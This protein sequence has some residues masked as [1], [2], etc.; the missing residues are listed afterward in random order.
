MKKILVVPDAHARPDQNN[1]RFTALGQ[2]ICDK[3]PDIVVSIGDWADMGSLCYYDKGT[4][5]AEG[6]RYNDDVVA[7]LD[8]LAK[9][10]APVRKYWGSKKKKAPDFHI[11]LGNHENRIDRAANQNAELYGKLSIDDLRFKEAGWNVVPFLSPL[12]LEGICFQHYL[13]SG[14]MG[15]PTG[16]VNH[17]RSLIL[18]G[19]M[20]IVVGHSHQRDFFETTRADKKKL[21]GLVV[22]CY[23]EGLHH[24]AEATQHQWWSGLCM[25]NEAENGS[26]EH[27]WYSMEYVKKNFL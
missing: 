3:Q 1:D 21:F 5:A 7:S 25:L 26:A 15:K 16:G 20:S 27:A 17:A 19:M 6:R 8:A 11:T 10:M 4:K 22:G 14:A 2:F 24:Y 12:T 23:D 9:T 18:K 13:P